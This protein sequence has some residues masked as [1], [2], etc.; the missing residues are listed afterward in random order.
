MKTF[1]SF[2]PSLS[3]S[4]LPPIVSFFVR[5]TFPEWLILVFEP[6]AFLPQSL[7]AKIYLRSEI[8]KLEPEG[9]GCSQYHLCFLCWY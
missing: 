6:A 5:Q 9:D 1:P 7:S 4:S 8:P 3:P 2:S